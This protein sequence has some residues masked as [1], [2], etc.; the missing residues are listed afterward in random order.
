MNDRM[1]NFDNPDFDP[2]E[3]LETPEAEVFMCK[4]D[5]NTF[6]NLQ[7][8]SLGETP[9]VQDGSF[10]A[11][12]LDDPDIGPFQF[13]GDLDDTEPVHGQGDDDDAMTWKMS[14]HSRIEEL[15]M[16]STCPDVPSLTRD[17][18]D[19]IDEN[20]DSEHAEHNVSLET[21]GHSR[22]PRQTGPQ[23]VTANIGLNGQKTR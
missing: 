11:Y 23:H 9:R 1:N 16:H 5:Q 19:I 13:L 6:G 10:R 22:N 2:L 18:N 15:E 7:V 21:E 14:S 17:L 4:S 8:E 12:V 20:L 3:F